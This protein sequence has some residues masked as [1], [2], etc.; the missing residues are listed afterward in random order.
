[1]KKLLGV[2]L[3]VALFSFGAFAQEGSKAQVFGGY[4]FTSM[5]GGWHGNGWNASADMFANK[6]FGITGDFSGTY[7]SSASFLTYTA[8]PTVAARGRSFSPFAHALFGGAHAS[9]FG[10]GD[11]GMAMMFGGGVD[12]GSQKLAFRVVQFDWLNVRF[13]GVSD[14]NNMRISTGV[15][16]RF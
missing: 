11:S 12:A 5:D 1:M 6:W 15:L 7:G 14:K 9:Q 4:Q 2:A 16:F 10:V 3:L 13:N 8:G